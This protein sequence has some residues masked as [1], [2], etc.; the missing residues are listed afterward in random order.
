MCAAFPQKLQLIQEFYLNIIISFRTR[1][2]IKV[3]YE[4]V[5]DYGYVVFWK[6]L[7]IKFD[8]KK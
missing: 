3:L 6:P 1:D 5:M 8:L 4:Y 2:K 7:L